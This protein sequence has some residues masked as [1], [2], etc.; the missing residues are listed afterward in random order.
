MKKI[1]LILI[2][3]LNTAALNAQSFT[4]FDIDTVSFPVMK[5]K[6]YAFDG[7]YKQILDLSPDDFEIYEDGVEREVLSVSCPEPAPPTAISSVLVMDVSGSMSGTMLDKAQEAARSWVNGLPLGKSECAI[8]SFDTKNNML[9]DFTKDRN[10][11]LE[12]I[13][14]LGAGGGTDY[15]AGFI[16]PL[17]G[18]LLVA[19]EGKYKKVVVFLTDGRPN[20]TP[21]VSEIVAEALKYNVTIFAVTLD[22]PCPQCLLDIAAQTG[23][24]CFENVSTV[25]NAREVYMKILQTSQ[26]GGACELEWKS[27]IKCTSEHT[28]LEI[29][30]NTID[31][32]YSTNYLIP[33]EYIA[34]LQFNP[35]SIYYYSKDLEVKHDTIITVTAINADFTVTDIISS[36]YEF[37]ISP[38]NFT[39]KDGDSIT[40][41]ISF[42]PSDSGYSYGLFDLE[43]DLCETNYLA[44]GGFPGIKPK[45]QTLKLTHP[46]GGEVFLVGSDTIIT[47]EG[48]PSEEPVALDY[49]IDS[50]KTWI[51]I[52]DTASGLK[53]S[54]CNIPGP[55]SDKCLVR[56]MQL[57]QGDYRSVVPN[58]EWQ[59]CLGG[60]ESDR[61]SHIR[62]TI[63]GGYIIAG[64]VKSNNG[65]ISDNHG[66]DD[67]WIVKL[68]PI[69][70]IDWQKCYGGSGVDWVYD[71]Q[72]TSDSGYIFAGYG[73][74][75][76]GDT[77]MLYGES[78]G[79]IVKLNSIGN[80]EWKKCIGGSKSELFFTIK[81]TSDGG[82][83]T[84]GY[85]YSNDGDIIGNHGEGDAWIVKL[86]CS[87]D[88][89]WQQCIGGSETEHIKDIIQTYD[90]GY[91]L[92]AQTESI[93]GDISGNHG[94][95]DFWVVKL[96]C[97]GNIQWQKCL[98]GTFDEYIYAMQQTNT[99]GYI[100]VGSTSSKNGDISD[101]KGTTD[102]WVVNLDSS[103][104]IEWNKCYGSY[105][106]ERFMSVD[107]TNDGGYILAGHTISIEDDISGNHGHYDHWVV[108]IN[109]SGDLQWQK[110]LGGT[111][112]E[113][114]GF[115]QQTMND[116]YILAGSSSS[117]DCDVYGNHGFMDIWIVKLSPEG[118][119]LQEDISDSVFAIVAPEISSMD[120][121][122]GQVLV[123]KTKEKYVT[124]FIQNIGSWEC[125][126]DSIYFQG[127][128][129]AAF[130]LVSGIPQYTIA[131]GANHFA[132]F[133]FRP[134]KAGLHEAEIVIISQADTLIQNIRGEGIEPKLAVLCDWIDFG[135]VYLSEHKDTVKAIIE[136]TGTASIEITKTEITGPDIDQF[137]IIDGG[138][139]FTLNPGDERELT[140]RFEPEYLGKTST[141]LKFY[142][143]ESGS[144]ALTQL[145]GEGIKNEA[146]CDSTGFEYPNFTGVDDI[147][148]SGSTGKVDDYI[149]LT[150]ANTSQAGAIC[151]EKPVLVGNGF[152]TEFS[153]RMSSGDN[154]NTDDGSLPGAD[155]LAFVIQNNEDIQMGL[156]GGGIGYHGIE[157][158]LAVEFDL[159]QNNSK[160][161]I[162]FKDPNGNHA[163]IQKSVDNKVS[164][165]HS[166]W[167]TVEINEDVPLLKSDGTIYYAKI[168]YNI[169]PNVMSIYLDETGELDDPVIVAGGVKLNDIINLL[170]DQKAFVGITS[171]TG[172]AYQI[173]DLLDWYF[174][175][176]PTDITAV[177]SNIPP[178][179]ITFNIYPNP[180]SEST[181]I[182]INNPECQYISLSITDI[183]GREVK[184]LYSGYQTAGSFTFNW[185]TSGVT[186]G[187]Y[188]CRLSLG[189]E[190]FVKVIVVSR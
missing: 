113:L 13:E 84:A 37:Y 150:Y 107:N 182:E 116:G 115:I 54:W 157:N 187:I 166:S 21:D 101:F 148:L 41:T 2:L 156:Y 128:D 26:G 15:E 119:I 48:I 12:K 14:L 94:D 23:G 50:G 71:I 8:T 29:N 178:D 25:E 93:D 49:R 77:S 179:E 118:T 127:A 133:S 3:L 131:S 141:N 162:D 108:K 73:T 18:G 76:D 160:Q 184:S 6:F 87:G 69:G 81:E 44:A 100:V 19:Q 176:F 158:A 143:N 40:L 82:F 138:G 142:H 169:E 147:I 114:D 1:A 139:S 99:G 66:H 111:I 36:N 177:E 59:K 174:C 43:N 125:R 74:S 20:F 159:F 112:S 30:L 53:Y 140:L 27:G 145:Y 63:N 78:D 155:G 173:H 7:D 95:W 117:N 75:T 96:D 97:N 33:S 106:T 92:A 164:A 170:Q 136:N 134:T 186:D 65:D 102:A 109:S 83:I 64:K 39:L 34:K 151:H 152:I 126:I 58:I 56:V 52:C 85:T 175:P 60:S 122:M 168:E 146:D 180:V 144:P 91:I 130:S 183:F 68:N 103:G 163:S 171:A 35:R 165:L 120:I 55:V 38:V 188:F 70:E 62:E 79:W 137:E 105:G 22:M 28:E 167:N 135:Q 98:G 67:C 189:D 121:D 4:V 154:V 89:E 9:Q 42:T 72:T 11:L 10:R 57:D 51:S 124:D 17:S 161:I 32:S 123:G 80:I 153:F 5:A 129:S 110:C 88:I 45:K 185:N 86:N 46:N 90:G 61:V 190:N 24:S 47:W 16:N 132:E 172:N 31:L 104:N 181:T 149:R